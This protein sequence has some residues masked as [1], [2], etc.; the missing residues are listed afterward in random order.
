MRK[1]YKSR[2]D[3][4]LCGICGGLGNFLK[5]DPTIIRLITIFI[6]ILTGLFPIL[7][8]YF[9]GCLVIPQEPKNYHPEPFKRFYRSRKK[10]M[11]AGIC[12]GIAEAFSVD[13]TII[14][15]LFIVLLFITGFLP[16]FTAYIVGWILIP[17]MPSKKEA[18][19]DITPK[20]ID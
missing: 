8:A 5:I 4:K 18:E 17:E 15:L 1:L 9:I 3:R 2:T 12:G 7:I 13:P 19:I 16:L 20:D 14:R 6:G 11:I 10:K